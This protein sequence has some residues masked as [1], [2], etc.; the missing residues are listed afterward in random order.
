MCNDARAAQDAEDS[1]PD[2]EEATERGAAAEEDDEEAA[3]L[4]ACAA[5]RTH[6]TQ[7]T[8]SESAET[9]RKTDADHGHPHSVRPSEG[10]H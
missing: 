1:E 7:S 5:R 2:E 10:E 9:H 8:V 3:V 4:G 6:F